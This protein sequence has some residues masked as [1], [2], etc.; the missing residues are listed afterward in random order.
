MN[1]LERRAVAGLSMVYAL[2]MLGMFMILPVFALYAHD[3]PGGAVAAWQIG[4]AIG[5]YGL[6][7]AALQIP[8]GMLSDRIGRKPVIVVGMAIFAL[9]SF[10][11][12]ATQDI[13]WII[14]GR[15]VQGM[16]AVSSAVSALL[17]DVTRESVRTLAMTLLGI[18]LG[19]SFILA[20][21]LG[22]VVAGWIGVDGIFQAT[23][24][25]ALIAIPVVLWWV[26]DPPA[27][28]AEAV[29]FGSVTA[30]RELRRL[31]AGIFLLH[32]CMT[33]LFIAAPLAI[34]ETLGLPAS[35][36][37]KVYLPVLLVSVLPVLTLS[38]RA[39]QQGRTH[40]YLLVAIATLALSLILASELHKIAFGLVAALL[41]YFAAFN[42]LEGSLPS[43]ISRIAPPRQRGAAMGIYATAQ[44]LG[45]FVGSSIGGYALGHWGSGGV[46]ACAAL[47]PVI[48]LVFAC[49][50]APLD[51]A[52]RTTQ[53]NN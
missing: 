9:G 53:S 16:G 2:R 28:T 39:E 36:H 34:A 37:W 13:H 7:Q 44:F 3:L 21:V 51:L 10:I 48:W 19:L 11:A 30:N 29:N 27:A 31:D 22:P 15:A 49:K 50:P 41:L 43:M 35:A 33:A 46:F 4:L 5:I 45:G 40:A 32:A 6:A 8:L 18:G 25:S 20:L 26:P 14:F 23:G 47:L 17:A 12:G 42:Y 52:S 24:I 38:R 1:S